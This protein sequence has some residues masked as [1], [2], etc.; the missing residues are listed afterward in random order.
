MEPGPFANLPLCLLKHVY[1]Y[2]TLAELNVVAAVSRHWLDVAATVAVAQMASGKQAY[3]ELC[4]KGGVGW[5]QLLKP[6]GANMGKAFVAACEAGNLAAAKWI[7]AEHPLDRALCCQSATA[8][9]RQGRIFIIRWLKRMYIPTLQEL[10][11]VCDT[12]TWTNF[13]RKARRWI[14]EQMGQRY[15]PKNS[16]PLDPSARLEM[17]KWC[18][19]HFG[20]NWDV[21]HEIRWGHP[22]TA[23]WLVKQFGAP[24]FD[25]VALAT[26]TRTIFYDADNLQAMID[27]YGLTSADVDPMVERSFLICGW[28]RVC[29][30]LRRRYGAATGAVHR[31][32][33]YRYSRQSARWEAERQGTVMAQVGLVVQRYLKDTYGLVD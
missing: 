13:D 27:I 20:E 19:D 9:V 29:R 6:D 2:L 28:L 14:C 1:S 32:S 8:A 26:T 16:R 25:F 33:N 31:S 15:V 10:R 22:Q 21:D 7:A 5:L 24:P 30:L 11:E 4:K 18:A 12:W 3:V 17:A 23:Q